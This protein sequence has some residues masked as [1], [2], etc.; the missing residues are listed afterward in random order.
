MEMNDEFL[1]AYKLVGWKGI[2]D[3][4]RRVP[5]EEVIRQ[6][7]A[8]P[9]SLA[10]RRAIFEL[11]L[12]T[13]NRRDAEALL[14][15]LFST[16]CYVSNLLDGPVPVLLSRDDV[17]ALNASGEDEH[18]AALVVAR[19]IK[20]LVRTQAAELHHPRDEELLARIEEAV[21]RVGSASVPG[22]KRYMNTSQVGE[23]LGLATKTVR[24]LFNQGKLIGK[25]VGNEWRATREQLEES[26]YL[27]KRRRKADAA[28]E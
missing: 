12:T 16:V 1:T 9:E 7:R 20:R 18:G 3:D 25:K 26:P 11:V 27:R 5:T 28:L 15:L 21:A 17:N 24:C 23:W 8:D 6:L 2:E 4:G 22:N 13:D 14:R 10:Y 19:S